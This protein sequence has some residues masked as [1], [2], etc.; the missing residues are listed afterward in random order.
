MGACLLQVNGHASCFR[1]NERT[2]CSD[3]NALNKHEL[4]IATIFNANKV[5][6]VIYLNHLFK[7]C[8]VEVDGVPV[9]L[10]DVSSLVFIWGEMKIM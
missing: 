10:S 6:V 2:F 9:T 5:S 1:Q 7:E 4:L 8:Y 3:K